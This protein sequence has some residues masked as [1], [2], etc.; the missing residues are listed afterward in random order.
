MKLCTRFGIDDQNLQRRR[1]FVRLGEREQALLRGLRPWAE[2]VAPVIAKEFYD[3]QFSF[4]ATRAFFERHA[5]RRGMSLDSLRG[6]LERTQAEYFRSLFEGADQGWPLAYFDWRLHIGSVHDRI[7]LPLKWY[8]G[9]YSELSRLTRVHLRASFPD[10]SW[11]DAEEALHRAFN[12]DMQAIVDSFLLSTLEAMGLDVSAIAADAGHDRTEHVDQVKEALATILEQAAAIADDRLLD[13]ILD[14]R[15]PVGGRLGA[16]FARA[17]TNLRH[18]ATEM[19]ALAAGD[20]DALKGTDETRG[21]L[22]AATAI[23]VKA[24]RELL[25][26]TTALAESAVQGKLSAR[27][28]LGTLRG[29]WRG[30]VERMN[31][32]IDAVVT[33]L[34]VAAG[35][36]GKMATGDIPPAIQDDY[37]GD[38]N[39]IKNSLNGLIESLSDIESLSQSIAEG[40]L[41]M[42][43]VP[44]S[45]SDALLL[46]I[47]QMV[48][49]LNSILRRVASISRQVSAAA[50][51]VAETSQTLSDGATEQ[52]SAL[53]ETSGSMTELAAQTKQNAENAR[54]ARDLTVSARQSAIVGNSQMTEMVAAMREIDASSKQISKI[55][56]VIDEI[57]FQTNLLALNAAVEAARAGSH[58]KGFAVVAEEVRNLATRSANAARESTDMIARSVDKVRNGMTI[59]TKTATALADIVEKVGKVTELVT[60]IAEASNE[61]ATGIGHTTTALNQIEIVTERN[62]QNAQ[63]TATSSKD[64]SGLSDDL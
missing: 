33:P 53:V 58:G 62:S 14:R 7:D 36:L 38:F 13:P 37:R 27:G 32:T 4:G 47:K 31:A 49:Q 3:W 26:S 35:S 42:N 39:D 10:T 18:T 1:Q 8:M 34:R 46:S 12:L 19:Q 50:T 57:A 17:V 23:T 60:T 41:T 30:L 20:I 64:L 9:A 25:R 11:L 15:V 56:K 61:Q 28:D 45:D 40:D 48:D 51:R 2:K 22:A 52:A 43:V 21:V 5:S 6:S 16:A 29:S 54:D 44:R 24:L 59:A 55:I 63:A